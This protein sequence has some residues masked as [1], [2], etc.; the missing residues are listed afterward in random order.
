MTDF[1]AARR[2]MVDAQIR[3]ADVTKY[4]VIDALLKVARESFVP[5]EV[6]AIAYVGDHVPMGRGRALL[7]TRVLAKLLDALELQPDEKVL[8]IGS[9]QGYSAAVIARIAGRVVAL[10]Q[11]SDLAMLAEARLSGDGIANASVVCGP[12]TEGA[13]KEAPFDAIILQ[14]A[15]AEIPQ[16]LIGQ[17]RIGGRIAAIFSDGATGQA[18]LGIRGDNGVS[19]RRI[20]DAAAPILPGFEAEAKFRF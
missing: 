16:A 5:N 9:L 10:E 12:L 14:G 19:W 15:A 1:V 20:F 7:E 4:V 8:D 2:Q 17:L 3:P 6:R 11:D 13:P 18:R